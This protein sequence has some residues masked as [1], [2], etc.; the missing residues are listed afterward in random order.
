MYALEFGS[1][2]GWSGD[3]SSNATAHATIYTAESIL[4]MANVG[5]RGM[6]YWQVSDPNEND[7]W[8]SIYHVKEGRIYRG[9]HTYPTYRLLFN[10]MRPGSKVYPLKPGSPKTSDGDVWLTQRSVEREYPAQHVWGSALEPPT[11]EKHLLVICDHPN[12]RRNVTLHLPKGWENL[13]LRKVVKDPIRLGIPAGE[14]E[15]GPDGV[16]RDVLAPYSL[17]VYTTGPGEALMPVGSLCEQPGML[18]ENP[19]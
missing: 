14:F 6:M 9:I 17:Q 8:W 2:F 10:Y 4:R 3:F 1:Y 19:V 5:V 18:V 15:T 7:G 13:T 16:I 12:E 11:G